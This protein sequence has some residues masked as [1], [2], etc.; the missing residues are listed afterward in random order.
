M[1]KEKSTVDVSSFKAK[2][3]DAMNDDL[4]TPIVLSHLFDAVK[5]I[6]STYE[7]K[8]DLTEKDIL[9]LK[10]LFT[11]YTYNIFGLNEIEK[12]DDSL[13]VDG[14]IKILLEIRNQS[15][16]KKDWDT[17]DF[18]RNQ[19]NEI[20]IEIKDTKDGSTWKNKK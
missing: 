20:N 12:Q 9:E 1:P 18:I 2:C 11:N 8:F 5:I 3:A 15:K 4:N 19:L 6:N 7:N 17:A 16:T 13:M 10:E 14:I